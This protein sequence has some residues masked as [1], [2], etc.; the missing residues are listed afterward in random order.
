[1][2]IFSENCLKGGTYLVTGAS[3]GI[4]QATASMIAQFGGKVIASGRDEARLQKT[5][6]ALTPGAPHAISVQALI[7]ADQTVDW[8][9]GLVE[10]HGPLTGVFHAAGVELIRPVRLTKQVHLNDV[11]GSSLYSAF[12]IARAISQKNMFADGGSVVFMSSVGG[13]IGQSGMTAY[14]AAKAGIDGMVRSLACELASRSIR[15]NSIAA[16]AI[17]TAMHERYSKMSGA[18]ATDDFEKGHLLGFGEAEDVANAA[19]FL[20]SAASRWITGSTLAVD[21]GYMV[22]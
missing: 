9:K 1:M 19:L 16:G 7:D 21:G 10:L 18:E 4:G 22:R 15:V 14:S 12:G 3:S 11:F 6:S 2:N 17:K 13:S 20:L 8:I 5:L